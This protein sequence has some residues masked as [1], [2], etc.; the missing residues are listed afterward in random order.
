MMV[1]S[2]ARRAQSPNFEVNIFTCDA[3]RLSPN[4][5]DNV[6][7]VSSADTKEVLA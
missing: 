4:F 3:H 7:P 1:R 6:S 5:V 2:T